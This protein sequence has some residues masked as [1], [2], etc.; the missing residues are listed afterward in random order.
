MDGLKLLKEEAARKRKQTE[1][2]K[3]TKKYLKRSDIERGPNSART[4]QE[5]EEVKETSLKTDNSNEEPQLIPSMQAPV[6]DSPI[7]TIPRAE[8]VRRLRERGEP[9][10]LFG[11][12]DRDV[13]LRLRQ[14][15]ILAPEVD[16][17]FRNDFKDALD[18]LDHEYIDQL[19][20]QEGEEG[21]E[22]ADLIKFKEDG[23]TLEQITELMEEIN[24]GDT[25]KD[26][27]IVLKTLKFLLREWAK[28]LNARSSIAKRSYQG[29]LASATYK[30]TETYLQPLF[31]QLKK[32]TTIPDIL[33]HLCKI[34]HLLIQREYVKA[35]DTYLQMAI[36]N[37]PWPI[38]VTMVGIHARTGREKI[39]ARHVAH[40][41][42]DETQRK[43][44][45]GLKRLMT[46]SQRKFKTD[47]SKCVEY[48]PP[49]VSD[50]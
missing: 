25:N 28:D 4:E 31:R 20:R 3:G 42:N 26:Q 29:K 17:G 32:K 6:D 34:C 27:D 45:Q 5:K 10:R 30:Q 39:F 44:I 40:V 24:K 41:L 2:L 7:F 48:H 43:Y 11:E 36:G 38:G 1:E 49:P 23:T 15:E 8:V 13:C 12:T 46:F 21:G 35:S 14:I 16:K 9:I 50:N 47:P 37:A 33:Q 22:S 18:K 19:A